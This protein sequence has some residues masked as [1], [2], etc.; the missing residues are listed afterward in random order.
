MA[1]IAGTAYIRA[2]S[3]NFTVGGS[4]S[5]SVDSVSRE[6]IKGASGVAGYKETPEAAFVEFEHIDDTDLEP[7]DIASMTDVTVTMY[8]ING[9][10]VALFNAWVVNTR[11]WN[12]IDGLTTIRFEAAK[13]DTF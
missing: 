1:A 10:T 8:L 9:K 2:G 5:Y 6:T 12:A 11:E 13:G 7:S 4:A 3:K